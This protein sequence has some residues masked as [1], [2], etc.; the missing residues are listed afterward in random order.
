MR[1]G[2]SHVDTFDYKPKL[3][4]DTGTPGDTSRHQAARLEMEVCAA[5]TERTL[6]FRALPECR[7]TCRRAL[8]AALD[9]DRS[10][11]A[12]AGLPANAH[13][14]V[15]V[16]P[17]VARR[18]DALRP[19]QRKRKPPRLRHAD[20]AGGLRR[21]AEL[22]LFV[23]PRDLSRHA[24]RRRQSARSPAPQIRNLHSPLR[25]EVQRAELDLLQT[26]NRE[27]LRIDRVQSRRRGGDRELRTRLPD[28]EG[29]A[30]GD[31]PLRRE[32]GDEKAVRHRRRARRRWAW[33]RR[34]EWEHR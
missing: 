32:R 10:A 9:A 8:P 12:S 13:R 14:L 5:R 20:A 34:S 1:G 7:E 18:L 22:W 21:C 25:T 6:D 23:S 30:A 11:R 3:T 26:L 15:S 33:A 16:R 28:A 4:A 17:A 27:T 24:H 31:G 29:N 2:P 19:R